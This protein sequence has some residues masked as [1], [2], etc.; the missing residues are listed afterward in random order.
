MP[1][2]MPAGCRTHITGADAIVA[3]NKDSD[4]PIFDV[5]NYGIVG[6]LNEVVPAL[7]EAFKKQKA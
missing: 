6:N 5:A 7:A 2:W 3:I 4:A 1:L